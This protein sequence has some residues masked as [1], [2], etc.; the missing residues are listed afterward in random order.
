MMPHSCCSSS[1]SEHTCRY[2]RRLSV[3]HNSAH[4]S[5][6]SKV[7]LK[8]FPFQMKILFRTKNTF[9][10]HPSPDRI[11]KHFFTQIP[12]QTLAYKNAVIKTMAY[13]FV[14][15]SKIDKISLNVI[16]SQLQQSSHV[17][18]IQSRLIAQSEREWPCV[19]WTGVFPVLMYFQQG[20]LNRHPIFCWFSSRIRWY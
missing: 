9:P 11:I 12:S 20:F 6:V 19:W 18:V 3:I 4:Q 16:I 10:Q 1:I 17:N 13:C 8:Q 5:S 14:T 2:L 7:V 15:K